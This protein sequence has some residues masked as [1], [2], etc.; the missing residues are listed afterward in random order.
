MNIILFGPPGAGKGTQ[1]DTIVKKFKLFKVS[2]GDLLRVEI[3]KES[4]MGN[5]IKKIIDKGH[6]VSDHIINGLI[7]NVLSNQNYTNKFI[8]D[9]Y[10]R[11]L[12]QAKDLEKILEKYNQ[13]IS[14]VFNLF[15]KKEIIIKRIIGRR[16]CSNCGLIFNMFFNPPNKGNHNC[17]SKYLLQRSDDNE[18][19]VKK[20]FDT[21]TEQTLPVL[22][23]Y[24]KNCIL[25]K[26]DGMR[27]IAEI[28]KEI[29]DILITLKG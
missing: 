27:N 1:A 10:P 7:E 26:I 9:G 24:K 4:L 23:H 28:Y 29:Q 15:V 6:F 17:E 16:I 25:H 5:E 22:E 3:N 12:N 19:V 18:I 11:N 20:R 2:T 21:Y 8:F 14:C 13:K